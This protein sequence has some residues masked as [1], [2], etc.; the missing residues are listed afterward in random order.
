M[1][2]PSEQSNFCFGVTKCGV[3]LHQR[4]NKFQHR[5]VA[6]FL[7]SSYR[8]FKILAKATDINQKQ[9]M[10]CIYLIGRFQQLEEIVR[11]QNLDADMR[12]RIRFLL[13]FQSR[14]TIN[15]SIV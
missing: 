15:G 2:F 1:K 4:L 11:D 6:S 13:R 3:I 8:D 14:K 5:R 12:Q 9:R 7:G 10:R